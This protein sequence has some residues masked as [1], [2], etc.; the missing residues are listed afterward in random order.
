MEESSFAGKEPR[1]NANGREYV[2]E[3]LTV[4]EFEQRVTCGSK[5]EFSFP[6]FLIDVHLRSL[7]VGLFYE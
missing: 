4:R 1:M 3:K 7:A 6:L 5:N 2:T